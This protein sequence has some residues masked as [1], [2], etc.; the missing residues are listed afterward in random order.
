MR[1]QGSL[2]GRLIVDQMPSSKEKPPKAAPQIHI[3][4]L[5]KPPSPVKVTVAASACE[6]NKP[7]SKLA[8]ELLTNFFTACLD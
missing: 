1:H 5:E 2:Q 6:R 4:R 8:A 7:A 3:D